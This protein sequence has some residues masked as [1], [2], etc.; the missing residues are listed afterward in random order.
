M[1]QFSDGF[2]RLFEQVRNN[3]K[4]EFLAQFERPSQ[5]LSFFKVFFFFSWNI[6]LFFTFLEPIPK[7]LFEATGYENHYNWIIM[8]QENTGKI[9]ILKPY[10]KTLKIIQKSHFTTLRAKRATFIGS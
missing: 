10:S 3:P 8:S 5:F 9:E 1:Q 7:D 6:R 4:S 2:L